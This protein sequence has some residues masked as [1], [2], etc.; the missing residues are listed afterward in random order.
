VGDD[1]GDVLGR[2]SAALVCAAA[3]ILAPGDRL[4]LVEIHPAYMMLDSLDPWYAGMPYGGGTVTRDQ[5]TSDY[6]DPHAGSR[7]RCCSRPSRPG[8]K[9]SC[10]MRTDRL[11]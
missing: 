7:Y 4:V 11:S 2:R 3:E 10:L 9:T 5:T 1:R 6:D 8:A